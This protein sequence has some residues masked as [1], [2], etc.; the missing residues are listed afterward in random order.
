MARCTEAFFTTR[1]NGS[2]L[3]LAMVRTLILGSGGEIRIVSP[4]P[5]QDRGTLV[6]LTLPGAA[7]PDSSH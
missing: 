6:V 5:G 7:Q 4:A 1:E 2:G 3:G